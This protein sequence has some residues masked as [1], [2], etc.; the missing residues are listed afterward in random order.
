MKRTIRPG[1]KPLD[2]RFE[3]DAK[4]AW[5][6]AAFAF[7]SHFVLWYEVATA[8]IV[9]TLIQCVVTGVMRKLD[10]D[11]SPTVKEEIIFLLLISTLI[12]GVA[13]FPMHGPFPSGC[14]FLQFISGR[15]LRATLP[16]LK[17]P[18]TKPLLYW[19]PGINRHPS[20]IC[21]HSNAETHS[22]NPVH[23]PISCGLRAFRA[24]IW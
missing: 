11:N 14:T 5:I 1:F 7:P 17:R 22:R 21:H 13:P 24:G 19:T 16:C 12:P 6:R 3:A 8:S 15:G 20:F 4:I 2:A 10:K 9:Q 18:P 23:V